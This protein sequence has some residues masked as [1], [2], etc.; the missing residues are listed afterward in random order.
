MKI[1]VNSNQIIG[2]KGA[3]IKSAFLRR[4]I[5]AK[6]TMVAILTLLVATCLVVS[7]PA[8]AVTVDG[9]LGA[10]EYTHS[11]TAG[12]YNEHNQDGSQFKKADGHETTVYWESTGSSA[13]DGNF[14]LYIE[15]P[16]EAKNMIWGNGVTTEEARL[17]YQHWCSPNDGNTAADDGSN[18]D[19]HANGFD[20]FKSEKMDFNTQTGSSKVWF[21]DLESN[22]MVK[23]DLGKGFSK[24][25]IKNGYLGLDLQEY[26]DSVDFVTAPLPDGLG[27]D[28]TN[29]SASNTPMAFEFKFDFLAQSDID[30]LI[31]DITMNETLKF[32]LS[33]ERGGSVP[34]PATVALLGIGLVGLIGASARRK[35]KNVNQ[36]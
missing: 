30:T 25:E 28:R 16:V 14:Y 15:A 12:W 5:L 20:T 8:F 34:E 18:C 35:F 23:A 36:E 9:N 31:S 19:H 32:H 13:A 24:V 33:P 6:R 10:G 26:A 4:G 2:S 17:Y 29:S 21:G 22:S 7:T 3:N 11:F 1:P 27:F